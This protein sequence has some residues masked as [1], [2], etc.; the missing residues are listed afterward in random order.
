MK[1]NAFRGWR[2]KQGEYAESFYPRE[3]LPILEEAGLEKVV[4]NPDSVLE[5]DFEFTRIG[6]GGHSRV[7]DIDDTGIVVKK[8]FP[9]FPYEDIWGNWS[10]S[11]ETIL[12][13]L[14]VNVNFEK[15]L[16]KDRDYKTPL[17]LGHLVLED[18]KRETWNYT[19][20][21]GLN[22]LD[23][24]GLTRAERKKFEF[25]SKVVKW[26]CLEALAKQ[27]LPTTQIR[28]KEAKPYYNVEPVY[29]EK[30]VKAGIFDIESK[31]IHYPRADY[32]RPRRHWDDPWVGN[33]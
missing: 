3:H 26:H 21:T 33:I 18:S 13:N 6:W 23:R 28:W 15:A 20:M 14:Q 12:T 24:K 9:T 17:Y 29:D 16:R 32:D 10:N 30:K 1:N 31:L 8:H 4:L 2:I 19:L 27:D 22:I 5:N 25:L 7:Y 11:T